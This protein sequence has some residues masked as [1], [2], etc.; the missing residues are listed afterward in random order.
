[1]KKKKKKKKDEK[2]KKKKKNEKQ[3]SMKKKK[4]RKQKR[5]KGKKKDPKEERSLRGGGGGGPDPSTGP[6]L[7]HGSPEGSVPRRDGWELLGDREASWSAAF[8]WGTEAS[9]ERTFQK[10]SCFESRVA[11]TLCFDLFDSIF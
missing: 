2:S 3:K 4:N 6:R 9:R 5:K 8:V 1:M 10:A 11:E 7:L